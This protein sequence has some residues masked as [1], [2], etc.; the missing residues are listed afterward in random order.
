MV[1]L[2]SQWTTTR[3]Q[4]AL[5]IR[6]LPGDIRYISIIV[7]VDTAKPSIVGVA[8]EYWFWIYDAKAFH[9]SHLNEAAQI[10]QRPVLDGQ[11]TS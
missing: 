8:F 11:L 1:V 5:N 3:E 6:M 7:N 2:E 9:G 4:V 10:M